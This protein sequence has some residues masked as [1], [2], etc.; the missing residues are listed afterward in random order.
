MGPAEVLIAI[1]LRLSGAVNKSI[2]ARR[3]KVGAPLL[4][5]KQIETGILF[6]F[7]WRSN[8]RA[9]ARLLSSK[10]ATSSNG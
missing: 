10:E 7:I 5:E 4:Q 2:P 9:S 1:V 8:P 3:R 6:C